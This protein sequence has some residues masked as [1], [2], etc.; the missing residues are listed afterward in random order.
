MTV[1]SLFQLKTSSFQIKLALLFVFCVVRELAMKN[2]RSSSTTWKSTTAPVH[3]I[4]ASIL[5]YA[6]NSTSPKRVPWEMRTS[7]KLTPQGV[8]FYRRYLNFLWRISCCALL[9]DF[10][11]WRWRDWG[12]IG[13]V[14]WNSR[15]EK[16]LC[17]VRNVYCGWEYKLSRVAL[18]ADSLEWLN[19][20]SKTIE[21]SRNFYFCGQDG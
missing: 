12:V 18:H 21:I 20:K 1:K 13:V 4:K 9:V 15:N 3:W 7:Q 17:V 8:L 14:Q 16:D 6:R 11:R 19:L 10:S 5:M 2:G